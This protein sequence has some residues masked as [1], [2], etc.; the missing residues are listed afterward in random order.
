MARAAF[1]MALVTQKV[2]AEVIEVNEFPELAERYG[3]RAVPLTVIDDRL[4]I[5]G[6]LPEE[7]LVEQVVKVAAE[8]AAEAPPPE[9]PPKPVR[10]GEQRDSGLYIP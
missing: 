2:R 3:V 6:M 7:A 10:R 9:E 5:P 8:A 4:A 1:Q